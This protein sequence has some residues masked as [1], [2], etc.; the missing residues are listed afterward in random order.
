MRGGGGE[1]RLERNREMEI[2]R[3]GEKKSEGEEMEGVRDRERERLIDRFSLEHP[4]HA[5]GNLIRPWWVIPL[6]S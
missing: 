2:K 5:I 3:E 6:G 1:E 4:R